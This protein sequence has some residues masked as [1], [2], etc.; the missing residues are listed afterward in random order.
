MPALW[1]PAGV[2]CGTRGPW[3]PSWAICTWPGRLPV[4]GGTV[5]WPFH[6][7]SSH[8]GGSGGQKV[9]AFSV[10][11]GQRRGS[12]E[13]VLEHSSGP[14]PCPVSVVTCYFS[15]EGHSWWLPAPT[16]EH[17]CLLTGPRGHASLG[18]DGRVPGL[19]QAGRGCA[20]TASVTPPW[21]PG[22]GPMAGGLARSGPARA[23]PAQEGARSQPGGRWDAGL[24][25]RWP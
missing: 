7:C 13:G 10:G 1:F 23:R 11:T 4:L 9:G 22:T 3:L 24:C 15:K 8:R 19:L 2:E 16:L 17:Q 21:R 5:R 20:G 12:W 25:T 6:D 14:E 18:T